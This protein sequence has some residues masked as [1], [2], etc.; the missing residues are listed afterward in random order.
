MLKLRMAESR[1]MVG[2][3]GHRP[4]LILLLSSFGSSDYRTELPGLMVACLPR[5]LPTWVLPSVFPV[6]VCVQ[7][8]G[9]IPSGM[10]CL[11]PSWVVDGEGKG[12]G[13]VGSAGEG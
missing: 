9:C 3:P 12:G 1:G 4:S 8:A 10:E 2:N 6:C 7:S 13:V 11:P 5:T